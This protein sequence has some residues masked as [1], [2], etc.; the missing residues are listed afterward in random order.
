MRGFGLRR[1]D[2][3]EVRHDDLSCRRRA[4]GFFT[5]VAFFTPGVKKAHTVKNGAAVWPRVR[6][7]VPASGLVLGN[8]HGRSVGGQGC[9]ESAG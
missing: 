4:T 9:A 1:H 6:Q 5:G 3:Q 8:A 2:H 7:V